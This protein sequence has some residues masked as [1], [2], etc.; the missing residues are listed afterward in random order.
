MFSAGIDTDNLQADVQQT[1]D[2]AVDTGSTSGEI[3]V[4]VM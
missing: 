4:N 2:V 1:Q 3:T